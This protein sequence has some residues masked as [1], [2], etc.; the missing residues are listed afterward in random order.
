MDQAEFFSTRIAI[1]ING[2]FRCIGSPQKIKEKYGQGYEIEIRFRKIS[3]RFIN[4]ENKRLGCE[5]EEKVSQEKI[6]ILFVKM[7][8]NHKVIK[9]MK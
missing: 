7:N 3:K 2:N 6:E 8:L 1:M 9:N 4:R 5:N